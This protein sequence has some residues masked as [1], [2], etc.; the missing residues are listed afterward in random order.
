MPGYNTNHR[1]INIRTNK[2]NSNQ[3]QARDGSS[4]IKIQI[5]R[6]SG[7]QNYQN[8]LANPD[9]AL[10]NNYSQSLRSS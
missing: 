1:V 7:Y 9:L 3:D 6:P 5:N 4:N 8:N 10:N 2:N